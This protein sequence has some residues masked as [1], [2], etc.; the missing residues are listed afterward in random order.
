MNFFIKIVI[1][2]RSSYH[3][4]WA[5]WG[6]LRYRF[7]S[8][9][10]VVI[11][12]TGTNG[13]S[14]VV[15]LLHEIFLHAGISV[16]SI[17]SLRFK[18]NKNEQKNELKM[19]MPGRGMLQKFLA[20]C[21]VNGCT[22]AVLEVT[23]EGIRQFRHEYINFDVAIFTNLTPEHIESHGSFDAYRVMKKKLFQITARGSRKILFGEKVKKT[24]ILNLDDP[25][26]AHF[27]HNDADQIIEYTADARSC[28][29]TVSKIFSAENIRLREDGA[30]FTVHNT[31]FSSMFRGKFNISNILAAVA[32]VDA[33]GISLAVARDALALLK[34]V[35]GRLEEINE[36]QNFK[37]F[38]D[39]A[40]T[41]DA[42]QKV[43]ETLSPYTKGL[44]CVL[45]ATGGGRDVWKR[46]EFGKLASRFCREI[47]LTN[48]DPYD[49]NPSQIL[50]EIESGVSDF[51]AFG[52][53]VPI[54]K[55]LDRREAIRHA[56]IIAQPDDTVIITGKGAEPWMMGSRG[57]KIQWDD[58]EVV[59]E[60]LHP[61]KKT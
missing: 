39:Y 8:R 51:S 58:R 20:E 34:G 41:P 23:S 19:T 45:G 49:E 16:G 18:I 38:V 53:Q 37:V 43:Y 35:A 10:L 22:Y 2:L 54:S 30:S 15:S 55:I 11:G 12:V 17:S 59:R 14:T 48:E 25:E 27:F 40:H 7:P 36:G 44:V 21:V 13:K 4:L 42:L 24:L 60:E 31:E 46:P 9:K 50:L 61:L 33:C 52:G 29:K 6:A 26:H 3:W 28:E 47:I 1:F 32:A 57:T 56:L 5:L